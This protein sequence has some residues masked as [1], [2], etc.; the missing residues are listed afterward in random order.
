MLNTTIHR[1]LTPP[2]PHQHLPALLPRRMPRPTHPHHITQYTLHPTSPAPS[3]SPLPSPPPPQSRK[4]RTYSFPKST[5]LR[6]WGKVDV[7]DSGGGGEEAS[8]KGERVEDDEGRDVGSERRERTRRSTCGKQGRMRR[9]MVVSKGWE[10]VGEEEERVHFSS[11]SASDQVPFA[12]P[13]P[14]Q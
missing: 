2:T 10:V 12:Q 14:T 8:G 9:H 5:L 7:R 13:D 4:T 11:R 3:S 1:L 6:E